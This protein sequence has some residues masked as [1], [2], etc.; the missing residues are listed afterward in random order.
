MIA[1]LIGQAFAGIPLEGIRVGSL[2]E[3]SGV[4]LA[5]DA[6]VGGDG[7]TIAWTARTRASWDRWRLGVTVPFATFR[8]PNGQLTSLGNL[9]VELLAASESSAVGVAA[10]IPLGRA[11]T[12]VHEAEELWPGT[13]LDVVWLGQR[14]GD[15]TLMA[16]VAGGV[17]FSGGYEPFPPLYGKVAVAGAVDR[18]VVEGVGVIA[19]ASAGWWDVSPLEVAGLVRID[20]TEG[21]RLRGGIVLPLLSWAGAQPAAVPAGVREATLRVDLAISL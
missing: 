3:Q 1:L 20:P 17:H 16:R 2:G 19:E 14:P 13:G 18:A 8:G 7:G 15:T 21:M 6:V 9:G 11:Y 5:Q 4:S 12:W 10:H